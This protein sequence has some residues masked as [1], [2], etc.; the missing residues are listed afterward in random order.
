MNLIEN[1]NHELKIFDS[2]EYAK[3]KDKRLLYADL[4]TYESYYDQQMKGKTYTISIYDTFLDGAFPLQIWNEN[5]IL[6]KRNI[7]FI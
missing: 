2:I 7:F 1:E 6:Q 3:S 5:G 4:E